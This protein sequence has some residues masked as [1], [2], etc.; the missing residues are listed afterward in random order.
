MPT[1][2]CNKMFKVKVGT[3]TTNP[4]FFFFFFYN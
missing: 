4:P 2:M 3:P 1:C